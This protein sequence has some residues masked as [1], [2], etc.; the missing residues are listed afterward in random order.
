MDLSRELNFFKN[1][2]VLI[3]LA[4]IVGIWWLMNHN[5]DKGRRR[6][7]RRRY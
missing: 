1:P 3:A 4:A 2:L 7:G 5:K 6:R